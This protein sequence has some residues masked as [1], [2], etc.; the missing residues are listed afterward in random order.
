MGAGASASSRFKKQNPFVVKA[1][2]FSNGTI[3]YAS[4]HG[5]VSIKKMARYFSPNKYQKWE[6]HK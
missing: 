5:F 3:E 1:L 4:R 6:S 2:A